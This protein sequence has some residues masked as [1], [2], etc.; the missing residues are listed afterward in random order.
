MKKRLLKTLLTFLLS[1]QFLFA[2]ADEGMWLPFLIERLNYEDMQSKGLRLTTKE[3]YDVNNSSMKDAIV[4]L[5]R[6]FCTAE[7]VSSQ[8]LLLTNHHCS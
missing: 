7:V 8:G 3:I 5:G 2:W 6:G 1:I 4:R